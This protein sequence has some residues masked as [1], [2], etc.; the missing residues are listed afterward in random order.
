MSQ[1]MI[2]S[3]KFNTVISWKDKPNEGK[4]LTRTWLNVDYSGTV[5]E[6]ESGAT[7]AS[8]DQEIAALERD[9]ATYG[10][11]WTVGY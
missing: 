1:P 9:N 10:H 6:S 2:S 4:P 3:K 5:R 7:A 8:R 11:D